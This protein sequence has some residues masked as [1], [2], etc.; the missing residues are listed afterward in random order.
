MTQEQCQAILRQCMPEY[1]LVERIGVGSYSSVYKCER[2]GTYYAIKIIPVPAN[3]HELQ[4]LLA[5]LDSN[6]DKARQYLQSK[7]ENYRHEIMLMIELKG[8][9]NIVNI[10]D[11][12]ILSNENG[13]TYYIVIRMELLA[14]LVNTTAGRTLTRDEVVALGLDLCDALTLCEKYN[15][16]HRDIKP[17]NI[18]IHKDGAY[19]L[20]DFGVAKQLAKTAMGTIAGT[21]GFMAPEVYKGQEYNQT[22]DIYSLGIVLYYFL[23]NKKLPYV[24]PN[25]FDFSSAEKATIRRM[26]SAEALPPLQNVDEALMGIIQKAC[27]YHKEERYQSAAEMRADLIKL[28]IEVV[29]I[30][31]IS[32]T[33]SETGYNPYMPP[34]TKYG[35]VSDNPFSRSMYDENPRNHSE[36]LHEVSTEDFSPP[37]KN[38]KMGKILSWVAMVLLVL[39]VGIIGILWVNGQLPF[40]NGNNSSESAFLANSSQTIKGTTTA[41]LVLPDVIGQNY[42][43][44]KQTLETAGFIVSKDK[45]PADDVHTGVVLDAEQTSE[46]SVTLLVGELTPFSFEENED[47]LTVTGTSKP[48]QI[49]H[50]PDTINCIPVTAI[51]EYA[52]AENVDVEQGKYQVEFPKA[53][54]RIEEGAFSY[55][56]VL[57]N[58]TLPDTVEV[59]GNGAFFN[60][61]AISKIHMSQG[62]ISIGDNAF[63][64]CYGLPEIVL[65]EGCKTV[66]AQAFEGCLAA[67]RIVLPDSLSAIGPGAFTGCLKATVYAKEGSY[68]YTYASEG[69]LPMGSP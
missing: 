54:K 48:T 53:L 25:D 28:N 40:S 61:G 57:D 20:G 24:A 49:L 39:T 19:K 34:G 31:S 27:M 44:A 8:N 11:Y 7:V 69:D 26:N 22:A 63:Q 30:P 23:N 58:I 46:T 37:P 67:N 36:N 2:D 59:I 1:R 32:A 60:C 35:T 4:I 66:G 47:G 50:I 9:R 33:T 17:E 68:A 64:Y 42:T 65:P 10:E 43:D 13:L 16:V 12:K 55:C 14:S 56:L 3:D 18:L 38:K 52:F 6:E 62:I 29:Q 15:I 51:G 21:E 45:T 41:R 5:R